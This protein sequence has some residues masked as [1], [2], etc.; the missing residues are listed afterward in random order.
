MNRR[1]FSRIVDIG[2]S[3][4]MCDGNIYWRVY[5]YDDLRCGF[6]GFGSVLRNTPWDMDSGLYLLSFLLFSFLFFLSSSITT[7]SS[8]QASS[9]KGG[10]L[11]I[12]TR[13][14]CIQGAIWDLGFSVACCGSCILG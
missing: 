6:I 1:A 13:D 10:A 2:S 12:G 8:I 5:L 3:R 7:A 4:D 9:K 14:K 11:G